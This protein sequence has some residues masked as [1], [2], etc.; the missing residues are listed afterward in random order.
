MVVPGYSRCR[1]ICVFETERHQ[2]YSYNINYNIQTIH[3]SAD[4]C[5]HFL[6]YMCKSTVPHSPHY[7]CVHKYMW[8]STRVKIIL[9]IQEFLILYSVYSRKMFFILYFCTILYSVYSWFCNSLFSTF[10]I[11]NSLFCISR[12]P[13]SLLS[14]IYFPFSSLLLTT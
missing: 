7:K 12:N 8:R 13:Y 14:N 5:L 11:F 2:I 6:T 3:A 1:N 9:Y 10:K 4:D